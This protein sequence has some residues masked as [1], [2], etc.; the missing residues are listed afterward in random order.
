MAPEIIENWKVATQ[1]ISADEGSRYTPSADVF[2]ST[3]VLWECL[4]RQQPYVDA[5]GNALRDE[6]GRKLVGVDLMDAVVAGLRPSAVRI[7][8]GEGGYVSERMQALVE[9]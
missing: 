5:A 9:R 6:R 4:T 2:S 3:V 7:A 8:N 1:R